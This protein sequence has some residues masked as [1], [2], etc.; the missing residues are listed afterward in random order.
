MTHIH[1]LTVYD[2]SDFSRVMHRSAHRTREAAHRHALT[3]AVPEA[4][5]KVG[6]EWAHAIDYCLEQ[7]PIIEGDTA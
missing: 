3:T 1:I 6:T 7:F 5:E 2:L 4:K